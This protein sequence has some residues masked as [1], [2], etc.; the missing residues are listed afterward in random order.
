MCEIN[1]VYNIDNCDN[2]ASYIC[3]KC[4]FFIHSK[5]VKSVNC[6]DT[7]HLDK[8][9]KKHLK[10]CS[11][12]TEQEKDYDFEYKYCNSCKIQNKELVDKI[13]SY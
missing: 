2:C 12:T 6:N 7:K 9:F 3:L 8:I 10:T 11:K 1:E 5:L 13:Y 4:N